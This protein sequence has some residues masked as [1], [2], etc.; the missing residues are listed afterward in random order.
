MACLR[1]VTP[2][3]LE[4][5]NINVGEADFFGEFQFIPVVD[6]TFIRESPVAIITKGQL[7]GVSFRI[8]PLQGVDVRFDVF[9][10]CS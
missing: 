3:A 9:R 4:T 6:G 7:N 2:G 1:S 10:N 8:Y 5:A